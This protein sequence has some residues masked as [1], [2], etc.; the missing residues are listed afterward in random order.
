MTD[1]WWTSE[2]TRHY[3]GETFHTRARWL[4]RIDDHLGRADQYRAVVRISQDIE[5][6][7]TPWISL[8]QN[9]GRTPPATYTV[10][11]ARTLGYA[12][13]HAAEIVDRER[14]AAIRRLTENT[15]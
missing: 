9:N 8:W 14:D 13:L 2:E 5:Y 15:P 1:Q 3:Q 12:L 7:D 4:G 10:E 11:D 6:D